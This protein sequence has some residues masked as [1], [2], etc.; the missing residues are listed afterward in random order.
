LATEGGD[1]GRALLLAKRAC[2]LTDNRVAAYMDTLAAAY[3]SDGRFPDAITVAQNGL[4]LAQSDGQPQVAQEI[5]THL[6]LYRTGTPIRVSRE[7][8]SLN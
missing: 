3:A 8:P 5:A 6:E 1:P 4:A 7:K 2:A